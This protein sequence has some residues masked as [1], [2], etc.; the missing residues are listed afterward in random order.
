MFF[1]FTHLWIL[2]V[3]FYTFMLCVSVLVKFECNWCGT[4]FCISG[5]N[6]LPMD[7]RLNVD[8]AIMV[9]LNWRNIIITISNVPGMTIPAFAYF[10][11]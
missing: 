4:V 10:A 11:L 6:L 7:N 8:Y 2:F 1:C 5:S 9:V 3:V